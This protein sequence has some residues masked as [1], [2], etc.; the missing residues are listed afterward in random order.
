MHL[1]FL[2]IWLV[3]LGYCVAPARA[4][5][6]VGK[7]ISF[8]R[9]T[10]W[11]PGGGA[12]RFD[13]SPAISADD[14]LPLA[15]ADDKTLSWFDVGLTSRKFSTLIAAANPNHKCAVVRG[16][17]SGVVYNFKLRRV[18]AANLCCFRSS[19]RFS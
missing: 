10:N 5:D 2:T 11:R 1:R 13:V 12:F 19:P 18:G 6:T 9:A 4:A 14:V 17:N 15:Y 7:A 16:L 8:D 3:F